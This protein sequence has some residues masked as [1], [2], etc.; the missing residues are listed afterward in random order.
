MLPLAATN[1]PWIRYW[2]RRNLDVGGN[3]SVT[4]EA[5]SLILVADT[6]SAHGV[7]SIVATLVA[8]SAA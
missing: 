1:M 7:D 4:Q 2:M 3:S 8:V 5:L 6:V